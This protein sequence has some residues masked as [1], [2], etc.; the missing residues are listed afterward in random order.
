MPVWWRGTPT[1][2]IWMNTASYCL[3]GI[4]PRYRCVVRRYT[5]RSANTR[6]RWFSQ[7]KPCACALLCRRA[8]SLPGPHRCR[9]ANLRRRP[10]TFEMGCATLPPP[11]S[12]ALDSA[13][14]RTSLAYEGEG[15]ARDSSW[16]YRCR[17]PLP[18][19]FLLR[20]V[21]RP[22]LLMHSNAVLQI[23]LATVVLT[24]DGIGWP[25]PPLPHV[26]PCYVRCGRPLSP[27][28][29]IM[30]YMCCIYIDSSCVHT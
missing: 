12:C 24:W 9:S 16:W 4:R 17:A 27:V 23:P 22:P 28:H 25:G 6:R 13:L 7:R 11:R 5:G 2:E 29:K 1:N 30:L 20:A 26:D 10:S 15:D 3:P 19:G 14:R 18:S 8:I 21:P